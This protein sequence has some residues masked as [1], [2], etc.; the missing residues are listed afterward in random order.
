MMVWYVAIAV[1][2]ITGVL[3][4]IVARERRKHLRKRVRLEIANQGNVQSRYQ[5]RAEDPDGDLEFQFTLDGDQLPEQ[6]VFG[7]SGQ[8]A[9]APASAVV[10]MPISAKGTPQPVKQSGGAQEKV[11]KA[12]AA[13]G[14]VAEMLTSLGSILPSSLGAPL[15]RMSSQ[16]R[17]GQAQASRAQQVSAR[18][19]SPQ[20]G[21]PTAAAQR[22]A[23]AVQPTASAHPAGSYTWVETPLV[24]PGGRLNLDLIVKSAPPR[25]D[26]LR[27]FRVVSRSLEQR[28]APQVVEEGSL[29][30]KGG[31]WV[32]RL[33]PELAILT[34]S[35]VILIVVFWLASATMLA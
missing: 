14:V 3:L 7:A 11:K 8:R 5:L 13:G 6:I 2:V 27:S 9:E 25:D 21:S 18:V 24:P 28:D 17:R 34:I 32:Q 22:P 1:V 30:I 26:Q 23:E 20:V 33:L 19:G 31:F 35:L 4:I 12:S 10:G 15:M 29:P 16:L